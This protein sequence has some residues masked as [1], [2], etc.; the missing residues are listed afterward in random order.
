MALEIKTL[1]GGGRG[2]I[3]MD[4]D[5]NEKLIAAQAIGK[6]G[7]IVTGAG[8]GGKVQE[9]LLSASGLAAHVG[10]R[11]RKGKSLEAKIKPSALTKVE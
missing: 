4:L 8:R 10:K 5:K 1:S 6:R 3:L 2:V 11:A 7:V 9:V